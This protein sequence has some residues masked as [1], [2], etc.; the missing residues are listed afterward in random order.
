MTPD[1]ATGLP[2]NQPA[3]IW[4]ERLLDGAG[5]AWIGWF[6]IYSPTLAR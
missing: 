2:T 5:V 4:V 1:S 3:G 6:I